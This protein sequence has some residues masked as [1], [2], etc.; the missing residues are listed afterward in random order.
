MGFTHNFGHCRQWSNKV[1]QLQ[2]PI[3]AVNTKGAWT[4]RFDDILADAL[5]SGSLRTME[6]PFPQSVFDRL[7]G[8]DLNSV[9][10]DVVIEVVRFCLANRQP[11]TDWV[12]LPVTNFDAY[13][14]NNNFSKKW[15][16]KIPITVLVRDRENRG[17]CRVMLVNE[18]DF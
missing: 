12:V 15:L 14:G 11:D 5:E 1:R 13:F 18:M 10:A 2:V 6:Y 3:F 9:S 16:A 7:N 8:T 17:V 4:L